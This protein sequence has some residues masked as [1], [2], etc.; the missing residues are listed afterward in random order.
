MTGLFKI[1]TLI[2]ILELLFNGNYLLSLPSILI[3]E[4]EKLV[5]ESLRDVLLMTDL[6]NVF[7]ARNGLVAIKQLTK[8]NKKISCMMLD[9]AMPKMSGIEVLD[10]VRKNHH[11]PLGIILTS[12][13]S[14]REIKARMDIDDTS[15]IKISYVKKPYTIDIILKTIP[16]TIEIIQNL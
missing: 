15:I 5:R 6:V 12:G 4:D 8:H 9:L 3:V 7:V 10:W 14:E 11:F 2:S 13:Y 1:L 16:N